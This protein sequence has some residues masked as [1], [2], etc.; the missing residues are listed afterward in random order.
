MN[1]KSWQNILLSRVTMLIGLV[2][3]LASVTKSLALFDSLWLFGSQFS[4]PTPWNHAA[5]AIIPIEVYL[6]LELTVGMQRTGLKRAAA[7]LFLLFATFSLWQLSVGVGNCGCFGRPSVAPVV[8]LIGSLA[9]AILLLIFP[10]ATGPRNTASVGQSFLSTT[11]VRTC[12][13]IATFVAFYF[14]TTATPLRQQLSRQHLVAA[15]TGTYCDTGE[16]TW[17]AADIKIRNITA[18][19]VEVIGASRSC[20]FYVEGEFPFAVPAH[21]ISTLRVRTK[22][23]TDSHMIDLQFSLFQKT[24]S[25]NS[26]ACSFSVPLVHVP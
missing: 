10:D 14:T 9:A 21:G 4:V 3:I 6:G 24:H 17:A 7:V 26:R 20:G 15:P 8:K 23:P 2:L 13:F 18:D 1:L 12:L 25:G 22:N 11:G 5:A 16:A 19:P